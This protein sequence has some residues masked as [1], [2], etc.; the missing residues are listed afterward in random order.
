MDD[1]L[2]LIRY[3]YGEETDASALARRLSEDDDL[4]R[5][6]ER[7]RATK[8]ALDDRPARQPDPAVVDQVVND[9]RTAAESTPSSAPPTDDRPARAPSRTWTRRLQA[10]SAAVAVAL[11]VGLGWWQVPGASDDPA[12]GTVETRALNESA[13][14]APATAESQAADGER[15]PAWDEGDDLVRIQRNIERLQAHSTPD[16]WG[17]LQRVSQNRP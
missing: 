13:P 14:Q 11:L 7:L 3:L 5:E 12:G 4:Y 8:Q 1:R 17:S 16:R 6:Y 10:A 2:R 15:M 9:A